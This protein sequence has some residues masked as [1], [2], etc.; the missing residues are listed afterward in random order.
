MVLNPDFVHLLRVNYFLDPP[1]TLPYAAEAELLL[2]PLCTEVDQGQ[3]VIDP[4]LR[5]VLLQHLIAEYGSG[6]LRDVARL[7]WEYGQ[8]ST[9]WLDR[10]GLSEA[11]QLTALNFIDPARAQDWLARAEQSADAGTAV[12]ER[13]FVAMRQDLE[14]RAAAV[15]TF[16]EV[17]T[18]F[19]V[20]FSLAGEQR[21]L[22]LPMAQEVEAILG[23]S[24]VFYD[25]WYEHWIAGSD[26]DLLLQRL[27]GQMAELV[28]MCVS[29]AY[30]DKP[31]T[32]TEYRAVRAR[33]MQAATAAD[34]HRI[35]PVRVDDGEVEG[36]LRNEIVPDLRDK[37]PIE[38]AELIVARLNL[39]RGYAGD[40]E[41]D[42]RAMARSNIPVL[43]WPIAG[44]G[45]AREA[46]AR[47]LSEAI[48][49][50]AL[51]VRG[52]SETGKSYMSKQMVRN[53]MLLPGVVSGRFDF[54][55][56]T[57]M[58]V[59]F[60]AFSRP[61]G[62]EAPAGQT[63]NERLAKIFTELRQ[64]PRPTLLVFDTYEAAGEAKDWIEGVLLPHLVSALWLRVVI[65]GQ[66]VPARV[67]STWESVA[68]GPL[69]L[70][71]PSPED[72]LAIWS[73]ESW[74]HHRP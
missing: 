7:L 68:A 54:K 34:R 63:L 10:P 73:D 74:R 44:H 17:P 66:S 1:I 21:Q 60:E 16:R 45:E 24:T 33:L 50:R 53:A 9:P 71:P 62:I 35:F 31:W 23:R 67:G 13:W 39:V 11:Q 40:V 36:V 42:P 52:A 15:Q 4:E 46:F 12:D 59:E 49:E 57:N 72:W 2:S 27:Y 18:Q 69:T 19:A 26:A 38:A 64:R 61:L 70:Q 8:R 14:G 56:T 29:G 25:T 28:V 32:R 30:G 48:P 65:I 43:H 20:A 55:G 51:L 41:P 37:T 6:R 5:D 47:L 58:G 22:V 3:Y